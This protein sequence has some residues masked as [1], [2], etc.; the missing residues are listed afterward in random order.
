MLILAVAAEAQAR[1]GELRGF[2]ENGWRRL[3]GGAVTFECQHTKGA[4]DG[5][6]NREVVQLSEGLRLHRS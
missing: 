2:T 1:A 4:S 5:N 6:R 3:G